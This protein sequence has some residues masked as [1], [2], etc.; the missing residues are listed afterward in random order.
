[1]DF[2]MASGKPPFVSVAAAA[3]LVVATFAYLQWSKRRHDDETIVET[4]DAAA[5]FAE[6]QLGGGNQRRL[7]APNNVTIVHG[8]MTGTTRAF[9]EQLLNTLVDGG[10]GDVRNVKLIDASDESVDWWDELLNAENADASAAAQSPWLILLLPTYTSGSWPPSAASLETALQELVSDWRIAKHPLRAHALQIA[11]F[12]MGSSAYTD[13]EMGK[14]AKQA[15]RWLTKLGAKCPVRLTIGDDSVG[16]HAMESFEEWSQQVLEHLQKGASQSGEAQQSKNVTFADATNDNDYSDEEDADYESDDEDREPEIVDVEDMG[17]AVV[18]TTNK[19]GNPASELP[20]MVT[21]SQ[22]KALKKE[23]YQLIGTHSAVKLCR[24]TK[25]QLRGRGGCYKHTFYGITSYQC[26]EATPSLACANKCVFCWRHHK[27]PVGKEWK[28]KTDDPKFIV[29]EAID[30]HVQLIRQAKGIPGVRMDRWRDA[31]RPKHCA[32]SLVG[33]PI[34][35]PHINELLG[36]L[37][38]RDISTFLVTNGQHPYAIETLRPVTQLYV[39]VDAPTQQSL[40]EIDRPLFSDA[41][42]RLKQS[43]SSLKSKGQRTVARLTVVKGWNSDDISG[44]AQLIALGK[45]SL[46]EVKG[47]T[48]CG[49]SDASNLNMTNTPWH[50]EVVELTRTLRDELAKLKDAGVD[51]PEYGLACEHKHSCSVLLARVD[52][53]KKIDPETGISKWC[54]WIDY[55]KFQQLA[56]RHASDP[57]F[58]F[59]VE[60]Y[61]AETPA[62]AVFG[63]EEEGFDPTETRHRKANKHPMY[64]KYDDQ[65]IPTHD[66]NNI[67]LGPETRRRLEDAMIERIK[68]I[69]SGTTVTELRG[70]EKEVMDVSLMYRGLVVTK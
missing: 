66:S 41:W 58:I 33:E 56:G 14:P 46:V 44:Y 57:S 49:K 2:T 24:W 19:D 43:L 28:W 11:V 69:G 17:D 38:A 12:G 59:D 64:T 54:T 53:F 55:E 37:H 31:L 16:N 67:E 68:V 70:G 3:T 65:G 60:D 8:S 29:Q 9:A 48:F 30:K 5:P 47:V 4:T 26:M 63:A 50:H 23:G 21:P 32:L 18:A 25:H 35:Y 7:L 52:Q 61:I 22:A 27:N 42:D 6:I 45:V 39:S 40:I 34:M 36:E 1:M 10:V 20:E 15:V 51:V 13:A 62:W